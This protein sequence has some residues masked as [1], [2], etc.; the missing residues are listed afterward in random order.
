M[1][2][3]EMAAALRPDI[4]RL[5]RPR[6]IAIVGASA[7]PGALG[8]SVLGNLERNG[9]AGD[10]HLINPKRSE[11]AGRACL[12]SVDQLPEGV[13]VA[14][15]A[16]PQ[17]FVLETVRALAARRV[18]AA[19]IFSAGFAEA[20]ER[21][22]AEQRE[23]ARIAAE[24]GMVV[25]GPNCLGCINYL[26]RVPLTFVEVNIDA[27]QADA[28]RPAIGVVSQSGAMMTV[29]CTTLA[30]RALPLSHAIS[31]GNEAASHAEDYVDFLLEQ[32]STRVVAMIVEQ[33]RQPARILA[34]VARARSL[35]KSVVLLH[36]GKSSAARASAATHTGAMAGDYALMRT[37]LERA[38]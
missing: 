8:A 25:E 13:D 11:I 2:T 23:I 28:A 3:T 1:T 16:I 33:F 38:G 19:V 5:L 10:I 18:G 24:A 22:M 7:T 36:P 29:L 37:K 21:G 31:T 35:G 6:S 30:S 27:Q 14:V 26:Q 34:A 32:P 12:A 15:L 9:F 20:G 17:P 4:G